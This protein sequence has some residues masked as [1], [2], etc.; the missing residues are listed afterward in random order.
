VKNFLTEEQVK[1]LEVKHRGCKEKRAADRIKTILCLNMGDSYEETAKRL[2]LDDSTLRNYYSEYMEGGMEKLLS[3]DY[4]G[5]T[6][7]LSCERLH[8]LDKHLQENTYTSSKEI[9]A[10]IEKTFGIV[11]TTEGIKKILERLNFVY[12]KPKHIPGKADIEKQKQFLADLE[13]LR[14]EKQAEDKIYFLDGCHPRHNS[15]AAYGWIKRGT[16]KFLKANTGRQRVNLNGAYEMEEQK[17]IV[18]ED[19]TINADSTLSLIQQIMLLQISGMIYL[20]CDNAKYYRAKKVREFLEQNPRVKIIFL[21]AYSPNLNLI[22]RLWLFFKKKR[23][24]NRYYE[25]YDAFKKSCMD[26]FE[27]IHLYKTELQ[28]L[29]APNFQLLHAV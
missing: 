26:F 23:L 25:K 4:S 9:K 6:S 19:A 13:K 2:L 18:R 8:Q 22:E 10:Y 3:D 16:E 11:Y 21:P 24:W 14:R 20:I 27:N 17:V 5:G 7:R 28:T 1:I 29:M 12:K 15:I